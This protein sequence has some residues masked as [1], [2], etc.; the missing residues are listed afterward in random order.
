VRNRFA[1]DGVVQDEE[2][3]L[4]RQLS[5]ASVPFSSVR[6]YCRF[7]TS[8][9]EVHGTTTCSLVGRRRLTDTYLFCCKLVVVFSDLPA[10]VATE[11]QSEPIARTIH[12]VPT[13]TSSFRSSVHS[14]VPNPGFCFI[15]R[16][17]LSWW[18]EAAPWVPP[19]WGTRESMAP[20]RILQYRRCR[21]GC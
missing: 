8:Y 11:V 10:L 17:W 4:E 5:V 20:R 7:L 15:C 3:E 2:I 9:L 16:Q 1:R 13:A 21:R 6:G 12:I 19:P 18:A 14:A